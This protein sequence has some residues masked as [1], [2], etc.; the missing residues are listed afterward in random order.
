MQTK[1]TMRPG[2]MTQ[3]C[4]KVGRSE[5][6]GQPQL[7]SEFKVSLTYIRLFKKAHHTIQ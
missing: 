2:T 7:H 5:V 3:A 6:Q 4:K 1:T